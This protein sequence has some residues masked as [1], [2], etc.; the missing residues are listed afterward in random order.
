[1]KKMLS[2]SVMVTFYSSTWE[3]KACGSELQA[4][5]LYVSSFR[6]HRAIHKKQKR[7]AAALLYLFQIVVQH[8]FLLLQ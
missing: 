7:A 3:A 5:L 1:M 2:Q 6:P 4:N 8:N